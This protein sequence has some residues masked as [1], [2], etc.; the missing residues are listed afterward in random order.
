MRIG[1]AG[2]PGSGK[3]KLA[4]A[5]N[6]KLSQDGS[7]VIIIDDYVSEIEQ[8]S[9]LA[10]GFNA[11]YAGNLHIALGRA[12]RERLATKENPD[13]TITCGTLFETSSYTAQGFEE[14]FSFLT[15]DDDKYNFAQRSE[16]TIRI[17]ACFYIDLVKY[18]H[19]FHLTPLNTSEDDNVAKLERN[20]QA[21]F[22]AFNLFDH[23]VLEIEGITEEEITNNRVKKVLEIID[24][25]NVKEQG[26]QPE[27][28]N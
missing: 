12:A 1:L 7:K 3:T 14:E 5:L 11:A 26:V 2:V 18:E 8:E 16:A 25:N 22:Q 15:R 9:D 4:K 19:I 13:Y 28:S 17:M 20:L 6:E 23:T 10:L 21:A 27:E 24:A